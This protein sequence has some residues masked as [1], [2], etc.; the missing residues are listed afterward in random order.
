MRKTELLAF[1]QNQTD[2]FDPDNLSEVFTASWLAR[3]FAMQRNTA[4]HYLN[5]LVAQD[6]LVKINTR[7]VYFLHKKAFC[8]QFYPLSRSEYASMAEL[9]AESD[10]QPEQADHFS[11][12]TGHDGSLRKPIEQMKTALFYPNGGLP[13]LITGDSG[14]GKSYM[15]ELMHEFA[16]AQ[17]LLAPDA[18]FVSFNC[19]QYASN[20][21]LLAANLFGYVKGAFTGAQSDKAG[22]FEAAN[23]GMLFLDEVHRLDAQGQEKLFTWLD[24][25]EIYRVGETAQGLPI[26][27]RLVFA[28]TEDIHSTFLTTFLRRIPILVSLPDLQHRSREEKEAL[29]LQFFWQE[30]RTLAARLQLTPRLLQVLTQYV[31]RGNVDELKNVVKYAVASAWARSPGR[32]MLTVRLHDLPENVMAA[33]PA[34]SEAM[35]QQEPLLIEPQTSLVWLLRA[36]DPVQGL[37]YDVQCRVLAQYEAV[38]NKKTVWEEAQ[39]SMGE[40]IETLFDRLIFDNHDSSSPQMLLLI[41]HQ[42]REEYYRLEKRFNIQFNGNCLY[43]LSHYLIHRSR[44]AQSTINNEKARQ[45]EDFLVQKFPLLYRFC[46]AI[47]GA[48]TLKLDIE[49]QRID[50]LLLVLWF[51]KNGAISQQQVTRA[52]IL[53][54]GYATASSIANVAN[55]LL[56]SQLFESFDMPLDVTPEAIANQVM[57]YIE[58]HALASGLIILVDMGSL[59]A[60]HRHFNRRLSTPMAIINNVSTGMAMYV[61][62]RIL[63]GVM[64]EDIVREIGDDLAVEHQLYYPQTDKPRAILTTCATGLGAAANLSAL[65]KASIPEALGIDIVAC[66][67]ETLA[68]PARRE[69]MLSR[70]EVLAIV[71]TLDPHLADL[72]WISLDSLISGEGSRPLMRIFGELATAEQV[73]EINN[74]ILK[75]FS[76]RRVIESVTILDTAKVINQVEQF[77]LRYEHL[78]GRDVPNDR[79]VALYVHISCLIERLIRHASPAQYTGGQCPDRELATLREA[80]SVIES[81]Y[82]VKI[83]VVELC[84]IHDI[85]TRETEFIQED[86]DF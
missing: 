25:K 70:Y 3:R 23:G 7:P 27:L 5:Q 41:A 57:A 38:L 2:F 50:L 74:L 76:L 26:S 43:A 21:E 39:R 56:K 4:S 69:P 19:A 83:P 24:R 37:I 85:L 34:L 6:V 9:L 78:A 16:I 32:E 49:P 36:R 45:L 68:D 8:Q 18:P 47:L 44:Q 14:T 67:V 84:Y 10:R 46:E 53:A 73:S 81:G 59:N 66:D 58:S 65:L 40:E 22:A 64:L 31:Y 77:L 15:A 60:I 33:T 71:G 72:P 48:L 55:R 54:H 1:L 11:L 82:S 20:P 29:T 12:L 62:E 86:Q 51:H 42:V 17:E 79:K 28:T 30:A 75:N 35:G 52:I 61:G 63:Q 13:L 80:F